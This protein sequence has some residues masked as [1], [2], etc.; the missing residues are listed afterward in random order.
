MSTKAV[1]KVADTSLW[2]LVNVIT[3]K[4][5]PLAKMVAGVKDL[6]TSGALTEMV[7]MSATVQV[8]EAQPAPVLDT[9]VGTEIEAVLVTWVCADANWGTH[10]ASKKPSAKYNELKLLAKL[11][12]GRA[13]RWNMVAS[14]NMRSPDL[15]YE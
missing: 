10:M 6:A 14:C 9:P 15:C 13:R 12:L 8:P 7:S 3:S 2:V 4:E 1:V 5:V 11:S